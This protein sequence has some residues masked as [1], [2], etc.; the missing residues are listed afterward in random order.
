M[1]KSIN[2]NFWKGKNVLITGDS[3]FKGAWLSLI[4]IDRG[5]KVH[6][7]S[8][9]NDNPLSIWQSLQEYTNFY[10]NICDIRNY[11]K[12]SRTVSKIQPD[13]V[14]HLAAQPL[15]R[16]SYDDPL[17]TYQTNIIGTANLLE[18]L[19]NQK[20]LLSVVCITSDK[21]Y[22]N[23]EKDYEYKETDKMGGYDPYSS[24]KGCAE[25]VISSYQRSFFNKSN[26]AISSARA[27]NVIG[28][29][30]WAKDRIIPDIIR[31]LETKTKLMI[32]NP[33]AVRPFQHVI[34]PLN[35]YILLAE[36]SAVNKNRYQGAYNFG[37]SKANAVNVQKILELSKDIYPDLTHESDKSNNPHEAKL[38]RLDTTKTT[39]K[40]NLIPKWDIANTV[41]KTLNWYKKVQNGVSVIEATK[42]DIDDYYFS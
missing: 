7:L 15:V 10:K 11:E 14:F 33:E 2:H 32:R 29:G 3:G 39:S 38:L 27:G 22:E 9:E 5:A 30:D 6:G 20:N 17:S 25:L 34:E 42:S 24:S 26:I 19:R 1:E 4:L 36:K 41:H 12:L 35:G 28:G 40:L 23:T 18:S 31:S 21:C 13:F 8:L 37:P 16:D